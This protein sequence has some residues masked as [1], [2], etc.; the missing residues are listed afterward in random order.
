M[1]GNKRSFNQHELIKNYWLVYMSP[2][3][4][5]ALETYSELALHLRFTTLA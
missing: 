4:I 5:N 3:E 1:S 2:V